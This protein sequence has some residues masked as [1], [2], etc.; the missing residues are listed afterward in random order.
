[1]QASAPMLNKIETMTPWYAHAW[2]WLLMLGPVVV[3][4]AACYTGWIAFSRQDAMVV[5]DY[6]KQGK[7]INQD[8]R[9]DRAAAELGLTAAMRFDAA[10]DQLIG[11]ISSF[12]KPIAGKLTVHFVHSTQPSKDFVLTVEPDRNGVY[13]VSLPMLEKARWQILVEN[14]HRNWR[15]NGTWTWPHQRAIEMSADLPP[16][17]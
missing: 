1:M 15:L 13:T 17:E 14:E 12:G 2:P 9:R 16:A 8:L 7:A 5:D 11:S 6:Y 10:D 4:V 3:V